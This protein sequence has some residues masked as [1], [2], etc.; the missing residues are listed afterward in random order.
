M[1]APVLEQLLERQAGDLAPHAVEAREDYR[2]G[3]VIDDEVDAGEILQG[4]DVA[5]LPADDPPLHVVG[6]ELDDRHGRLGGM[7]RGEALHTHREDVADASLGLPLGLVLDLANAA[8]RVV[9][10]LVLD[11]LEQQLLGARRR[12][13][14]DL[15]ERP[16]ELLTGRGDRL[17]LLLYLRLTAGK[18]VFPAGERSRAL[19]ELDV[20]WRRRVS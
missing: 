15:L 16:L 6:L 7:A 5:A 4:A 3:R 19:G 13:P 17:A 8:C 11:L 2:P 1:D 10:G 12:Q 20:V 14:R 9:L 18:M